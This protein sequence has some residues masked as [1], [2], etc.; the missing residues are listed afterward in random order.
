M[1]IVTFLLLV[2]PIAV[3][4]I[5]Y[6]LVQERGIAF[7]DLPGDQL[8]K[9]AVLFGASLVAYIVITILLKRQ[10]ATSVEIDA[11]GVR[12]HAPGRERFIPWSEV[13]QV[14]QV[15]TGGAK[16]SKGTDIIMLIHQAG[17]Y[18]FDPW[19]MPDDGSAC[20][21]LT[22]SGM[23][24]QWADGTTEPADLFHCAGFKAVQRYRGDLM[25][26]RTGG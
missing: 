11:A 8:K 23:K 25:A 9:L 22:K 4:V 13:T 17:R 26:K 12:H 2:P 15:Y 16:G 7:Y 6:R 1:R 5:V 21:K 10:A 20:L 18:R 24:W 14:R 19:L 3:A